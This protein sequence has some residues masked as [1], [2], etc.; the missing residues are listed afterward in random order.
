MSDIQGAAQTGQAYRFRFT[1]AE[2]RWVLED[3]DFL[4]Q[5]DNSYNPRRWLGVPVE[6]IPPHPLGRRAQKRAQA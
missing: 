6:I 1:P 3:E 4:T 2:W 5:P